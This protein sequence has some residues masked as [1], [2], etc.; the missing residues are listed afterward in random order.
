MFACCAAL[1]VGWESRNFFLYHACVCRAPCACI[2]KEDHVRGG[3]HILCCC[4]LL[5]LL[6][7]DVAV[8][9]AAGRAAALQ[10]TTVCIFVFHDII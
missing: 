10:E 2:R 7:A 1:D 8:C 4:S 6:A 3:I 9:P 5:P